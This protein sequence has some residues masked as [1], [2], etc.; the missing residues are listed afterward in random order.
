MGSCK[1][2]PAPLNLPSNSVWNP[3][4][5]CERHNLLFFNNICSFCGIMLSTRSGLLALSLPLE[6]AY[7][8]FSTDEGVRSP[9]TPTYL[10]QSPSATR[11]PPF[12]HTK[13]LEENSA[14]HSETRMSL[15]PTPDQPLAWIWI[16][17]LCHS[18][19]PLGVT[20]R[21][22]VDGHYYCSGETNQPNLRKKKKKQSCSS[23]FDYVAWREWGD[24]RRM[25]LKLLKNPRLSGG[26][27]SCVFPSQCRYPAET[28]DHVEKPVRSR[29]TSTFI[30]TAPE[31]EVIAP[32]SNG[33]GENDKK[34]SLSTSNENVS[35][36]QILND[37]FTE[38][39]TMKIDSKKEMVKRKSQGKRKNSQKDSKSSL[40][41]EM[42]K[43]TERVK[44]LVGVDLWNNLEDIALE[45]TK[46]D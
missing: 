8:S 39:K 15:P 30:Q 40:E 12:D 3:V 17:H 26:C 16:C 14:A 2:W 20:R 18:R 36:D 31:T 33:K 34:R 35:F 11:L 44:Q 45:K 5:P 27:E 19:Y 41:Q 28:K 13:V 38:E 10:P 4:L 9:R 25:A 23:E 1:R 46:V 21:C 43:E 42:A 6:T 37:I 24:W 29:K 32:E 7:T 22:L